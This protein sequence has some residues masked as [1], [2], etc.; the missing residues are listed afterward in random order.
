MGKRNGRNMCCRFFSNSSAFGCGVAKCL[1][2]RQ[3]S[4]KKTCLRCCQREL[5]TVVISCHVQVLGFWDFV[6]SSPIHGHLR[7]LIVTA[8]VTFFVIPRFWAPKFKTNPLIQSSLESPAKQDEAFT[9]ELLRRLRHH[10]PFWPRLC[11]AK[12]PLAELWPAKLL[13]RRNLQSLKTEHAGSGRLRSE[14]AHS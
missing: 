3:K 6:S 11:Y 8:L 14:I 5:S 12:P 9:S 13:H 4:Q 2:V 10:S 7:M 1:N